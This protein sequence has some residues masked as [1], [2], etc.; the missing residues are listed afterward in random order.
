MP[1][2]EMRA[3]IMAVVSAVAHAAYVALIL[4]RAGTTPPAGVPY[5][6][7]MLWTVGGAIAAAIVLGIGAAA[8]TGREAGM[9]DRRDREIN[10]FG[11]HAGQSFVALG[12]AAALVL[13]MLG[14]AHF[15][16]ANAL[17]LA[18]VLSAVVGSIAKI[19]A[20]RKGFWPW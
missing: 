15:W 6:P 16:I 19:F 18:F 2:E 11:E 17:Y 13:A 20:Y 1:F 9:K 3:W 12:A 4:G 14:A 10:R 8:P 5:V 7:P